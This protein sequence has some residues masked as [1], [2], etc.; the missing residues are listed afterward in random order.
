M[1]R[2]L[3]PRAGARAHS[4]WL[5]LLILAWVPSNSRAQ[6]NEHSNE[7]NDGVAPVYIVAGIALVIAALLVLC[8]VGQLLS[9]RRSRRAAAASLR[10]LRE[11]DAE[12]YTDV[13]AGWTEGQ[14]R[15]YNEAKAFAKVH[16]P[17]TT[18]AQLTHEQERTIT[19]RGV[20]AWQF[21]MPV[22]GA[23]SLRA[24]E[25]DAAALNVFIHQNAE[26]TYTWRSGPPA[27]AAE[28][29]DITPL[30]LQTELPV[31]RSREVYYFE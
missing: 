29:R 14:R 4:S 31:P 5:A 15:R 12:N 20:A 6:L 26:L 19:E 23:E 27:T 24:R 8:I 21:V 17:T 11:P 7:N 25:E 22:A 3:S 16:P 1:L 30:L 9:R 10:S 13:V 2:V 28:A 18:R